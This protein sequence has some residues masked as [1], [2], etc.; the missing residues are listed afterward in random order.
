MNAPTPRLVSDA[1]E[2]T[3]MRTQDGSTINAD[4]A[5]YDF[6]FHGSSSLVHRPIN[7]R[8]NWNLDFRSYVDFLSYREEGT[9]TGHSDIRV[10][11]DLDLLHLVRD[12][13]DRVPDLGSKGASRKQMVRDKL[14]EQRPY[15]DEQGQNMSEVRDWEWGASP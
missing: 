4:D 14:I 9:I 10:Q 12:V 2:R 13:F 8:T 5:E 7:R 3:M 6:G 11:N 1:K 15:L